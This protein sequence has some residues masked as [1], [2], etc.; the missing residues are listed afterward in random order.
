MRIF[1]TKVQEIKYKV[2]CEVSKRTWEGKDSFADFNDIANVIVKQGEPLTRCCIYKERAIVAERIRIA[3]GG[4]KSN[5][6]IVEVI[7][8]ACDECPE[9]GHVVTDLCRGCMAHKC[10]DACKLGAITFDSNNKAKIDKSKCVE[11]GRCAK[12]CPYQAI[13]NF[14]RPCER[15]CKSKAIHMGE[16]GAASIDLNKCIACGS[17]VY[18]CPFGATSDKS[19]I[20]DAIHIIKES[21]VENFEV[22]AIM[23]PAVAS[24]FKY[25]SFGQ[26]ITAMKKIGFDEVMEVAKGADIVA[27]T[28]ARELME[29]GFLT[30][31]C[32]PS[33]V[34]Y[35]ENNYPTLA[36]KI[37]STLSPMAV[38]GKI[39]K[40]K[41]PRAKVIFVGPCTAKKAEA[42]KETVMPYID[43]VLTFEELQALIDSMEID[44]ENLPETTLDEASSF[45]REFAFSGGVANAV[46]EAIAEI[47]EREGEDSEAARF[48][49]NPIACDGIDNCRPVLTK[50]AKGV[51]ANNLIEGMACSGGCI[52]GAGCLTHGENNKEAILRHSREATH[53]TIFR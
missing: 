53:K 7:D 40:E 15:T 28:E 30:T 16:T 13:N 1:D 46:K 17:C 26:V 49:L 38:T 34:K 48:E 43:C 23:A 37:S 31:S 19:F 39:I 8:I 20:S 35:V 36:D 51:L 2:L 27:E 14:V 11:C 47:A 12:V 52:G 29:K 24:Q 42:K 44:I 41:D 25:A 33:F 32:C 50:A 18:A 45:G 6:N 3:L 21:R 4:K 5:P 10:Q 22:Y 9:A